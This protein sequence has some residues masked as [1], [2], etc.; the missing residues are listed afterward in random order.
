MSLNNYLYVEFYGYKKAEI[1]GTRNMFSACNTT[2]ACFFSD[3]EGASMKHA[4]S[5]RRKYPSYY[6]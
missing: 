1:K 3:V 2:S 5:E 4:S 6:F